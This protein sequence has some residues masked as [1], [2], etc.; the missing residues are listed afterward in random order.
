MEQIKRLINLGDGILDTV[1]SAVQSENYRTL[2]K[3]IKEQIDLSLGKETTYTNYSRSYS[4]LDRSK[5]TYF[6]MKKPS[7]GLVTIAIAVFLVIAVLSS[8]SCIAIGLTGFLLGVM[9][10]VV[11]SM[12]LIVVA[13]ACLYF[14]AVGMKKLKLIETFDKYA[15]IIGPE[16]YYGVNELAEYAGERYEETL[17]NLHNMIDDGM[18][19][20]AR[21]DDEFKTLILTDEMYSRYSYIKRYRNSPNVSVDVKDEK[22]Q[23]QMAVAIREDG[24]AFLKDVDICK[25]LAG[26]EFDIKTEC[27]NRIIEKIFNYL[28]EVPSSANELYV[29]MNSYIK[30]IRKLLFVYTNLEKDDASNTWS[31]KLEISEAIDEINDVFETNIDK[32]YK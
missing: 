1:N 6:C 28:D 18:L 14:F 20:Y 8:I 32:L 3:D 17:L 26:D 19:P 21:F 15:K 5:T 11:L 2:S 29:L 7:S 16:E 10:L 9:M 4:D 25:N 31:I 30:A 22:L 13:A 24:E 23:A 12:L 27:F